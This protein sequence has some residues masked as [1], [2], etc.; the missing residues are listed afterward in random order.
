MQLEWEQRWN[1]ARTKDDAALLA[2]WKALR[3]RREA[4]VERAAAELPLSRAL[5]R[6]S[7]READE[8]W[9]H[10]SAATARLKP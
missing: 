4:I 10:A 8:Y 7:R 2:A 6:R 9:R 5:A 3:E 1:G